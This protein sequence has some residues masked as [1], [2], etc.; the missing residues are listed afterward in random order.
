VVNIKYFSKNICAGSALAT[1]TTERSA[2]LLAL[3]KL[4]P[5]KPISPLLLS[6]GQLKDGRVTKVCELFLKVFGLR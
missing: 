6:F 5:T 1:R 4:L 3:N 2:A